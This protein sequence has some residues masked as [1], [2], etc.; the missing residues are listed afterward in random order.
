MK[1]SQAVA[2]CGNCDKTDISLKKC[3]KCMSVS[4][5]DRECQKSHWKTHKKVCAM[6]AGATNPKNSAPGE[7]IPKRSNSK[8]FTAIYHNNFLHDRPEEETFKILIDILRMRQ[9]DTHAFEGDNMDGSIYNGE[10]TSERAFRQ[11]LRKAK[12]VE[13]FLPPWWSD[14][15]VEECVRFGLQSNDFSLG[16]AQEKSDIQEAWGDDKM[17]MKLRM[18]G[19]KVYGNTP[20]TGSQG[21]STMLQMMMGMER[22]SGMHS[23]TLDMAQLF[24]AR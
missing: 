7:K 6:L 21:G 20:G 12:Q 1:T 2:K 15:K 4:Y 18:L 22:G 24:G 23:S 11:F 14:E 9:E 17:P 3:A 10:R 8:P 16:S 5:C 13:G 19:E